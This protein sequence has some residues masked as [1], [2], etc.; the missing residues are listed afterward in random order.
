M[1]NK[2]LL[3]SIDILFQLRTELRFVYD[4]PEKVNSKL[5]RYH[6]WFYS[7]DF[8]TFEW[9]KEIKEELKLIKKELYTY[10]NKEYDIFTKPRVK[11]GDLAIISFKNSGSSLVKSEINNKICKVLSDPFINKENEI[12]SSSIF[13]RKTIALQKILH[14]GN[15]ININIE[16][17]KKI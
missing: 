12:Y 17:L 1:S 3:N 7:T 2:K 16:D 10:Y 4:I 9:N 11:S 8:S 13:M 5:R 14:N 15:V 6:E